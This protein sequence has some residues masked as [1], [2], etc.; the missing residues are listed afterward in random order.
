MLQEY[1]ELTGLRENNLKNISLKLPKRKIT[2]FTGVSGSGKSS[3]VFETIA[4]ESGRLLNETFPAFIRGFMPKYSR[5]DADGIDHISPSIIIDQK[6]IGGN[7]RSTLGTITD[8]D[9][10]LRVMFS[11]I[12]RPYVG[13][14]SCFSFN[15]TFGMCK[16]CQGIGKVVTLDL[17]AAIDKKKSLNEGAILLP[18]HGVGTWL[19]KFYAHSK[20]F[21][22]DKKIEDYTEEEFDKFVYAK[23]EKIHL[24]NLDSLNS[25]YEGLVERFERTNMRGSGEKSEKS[26]KKLSTFTKSDKCHVC[27]GKRYS[28]DVLDCKIDGRS[29]ADLTAMQ[30]DE[31]LKVVEAIDNTEV[32]TVANSLAQ[33]LKDLIGIGLDYVSLNRETSTLSGGESQRVKMVKNLSSSLTDMLYIF[34]EPSIGLH[35]R[36]VYRLNDILTRL[37]DKGN[38]VIV[39][40]HDPDVIKI[41]DY[42]VDMG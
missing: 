3:V 20:F 25:T 7:S 37:R 41:A 31:L 22:C 10:L 9:P 5:P 23:P 29:I 15:D 11:K 17:D 35:P 39:V 4:Q 27:K 12:G 38:T 18:G 42:V 34:D 16:N 19:W 8:I 26:Q 32:S 14:M 36:D 40:E 13:G 1:I 21:D 30:V 28:Q 24:E 6:R 33:R 2:V